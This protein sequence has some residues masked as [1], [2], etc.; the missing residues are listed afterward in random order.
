M[1]LN[2]DLPCVNCNLVNN[3]AGF[4]GETGFVFLW[5]FVEFIQIYSFKQ[6]P[7]SQTITK[8]N[9]H[10][11]HIVEAHSSASPAKYGHKNK[12]HAKPHAFLI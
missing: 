12:K 10:T 5:Y 11:T 6:I 8:N 7:F 9:S 1:A 2:C 3:K 4:W